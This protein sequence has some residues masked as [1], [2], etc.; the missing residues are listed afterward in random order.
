MPSCLLPDRGVVRVRGSDAR[1]FL[2]NLV[3]NAVDALDVGEARYAA[4]L[5]PQGKMIVDGFVTLTPDGDVL[6]ECP[7]ALAPDLAR[8]LGL[9]KL[10]AKVE[11]VDIS[12]QCA[13]LAFWGAEA[14]RSQDGWTFRDPRLPELGMR[15]VAEQ[16]SA[17]MLATHE[18]D[19]YHAHRIALGVP[20]GG[21]DFAYSDAFP[22]EADMDLLNGVDFTKGCYVG[23]EVVSRMQHRG[24]ARTRAV[25]V[26]FSAGVAPPSG[27]VILAGDKV[28]GT[29]GS[30]A[31]SG[32]AIALVRL[33]RIEDALR[34]GEVLNADGLAFQVQRRT[35][36]RF[37]IPGAVQ[38]ERSNS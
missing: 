36:M 15:L 14:P 26:L 10:R 27:T 20:E 21:K 1:L 30:S 19:A 32:Q 28:A 24:T 16:Q 12:D 25:P 34:A 38:H 29:V 2:N 6:V 37:E 18:V 33:D 31:S 3:T 13:V 9:Y 35:W 17:P 11:I 22:H 8:R 23:Q 5:T 7:R 4:L